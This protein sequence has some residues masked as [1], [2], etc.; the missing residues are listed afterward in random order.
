MAEELLRG[1]VGWAEP[2]G[3]VTQQPTGAIMEEQKKT[4]QK[5]NLS[6]RK[7]HELLFMVSEICCWSGVNCPILQTKLVKMEIVVSLGRLKSRSRLFWKKQDSR[8]FSQGQCAVQGPLQ[9]TE[10]TPLRGC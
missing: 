5:G 8:A 1:G 3:S 2:A 9:P 6:T 7:Y 4:K 10:D